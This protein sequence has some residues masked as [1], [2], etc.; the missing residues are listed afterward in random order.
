MAVTTQHAMRGIT[1]PI[2]CAAAG[3]KGTLL[4][5]TRLGHGDTIRHTLAGQQRRHK[6]VADLPEHDTHK[7]QKTAPYEVP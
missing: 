3:E 6:T 2:A 5:H 7:H 1:V 4:T